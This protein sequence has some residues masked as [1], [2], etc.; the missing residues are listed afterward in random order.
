MFRRPKHSN[1][2]VVVHKEE[3]EERKGLKYGAQCLD[4]EVQH[5]CA[6]IFTPERK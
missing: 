4:N 2:E 5:Y 3:E 1:I 6:G